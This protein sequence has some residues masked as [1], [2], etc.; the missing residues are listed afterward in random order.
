[1]REF[2][3]S[4]MKL[5]YLTKIID[6]IRH[7]IHCPKCK[8]PF[9]QEHIEILAV[10]KNQRVDFSSHC[11]HCG[12]RSHVSA[13]IEPGGK[14]KAVGMPL[15]RSKISSPRIQLDPTMIKKSLSEFGGN[16]VHQL[17]Q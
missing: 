7:D 5:E 3:N 16:D 12:S 11:Q 4:C 13:V 1:M 9:A 15:E 2:Y 10:N 14:A 8:K 6:R 17:F